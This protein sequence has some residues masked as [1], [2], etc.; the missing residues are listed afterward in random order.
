[1]NSK[2]SI[3]YSQSYIAQNHSA[4]LKREDIIR[5][6][7]YTLAESA[8]RIRSHTAS[9]ASLMHPG[10]PIIWIVLSHK[11]M[12]VFVEFSIVFLTLPPWPATLPIARL[13]CSPYKTY[14]TFSI[15][16][17]SIVKLLIFKNAW[18]SFKSNPLANAERYSDAVSIF[19]LA[20]VVLFVLISMRL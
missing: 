14:L 18:Q 4:A 10:V 2:L 20:G 12:R 6:R 9:L 13:R 11:R 1:M 7:L 19:S 15:W 3:R 16:K 5:K 8:P 17:L